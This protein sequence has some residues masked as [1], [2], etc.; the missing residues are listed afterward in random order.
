MKHLFSLFS[1]FLRPFRRQLAS[2]LARDSFTLVFFLFLAGV[3]FYRYSVFV[4]S[5]PGQYHLPLFSG[6][7]LSFLVWFFLNFW[8]KPSLTEKE[9]LLFGESTLPLKSLVWYFFLRE[10]GRKILPLLLSFLLLLPIINALS[11]PLLV[12][13][14]I[15]VSLPIVWFRYLLWAY[16]FRIS[17]DKRS[18]LLWLT[19]LTVTWIGIVNYPILV[20]VG[21]GIEIFTLFFLLKKIFSSFSHSF[22]TYSAF[23]LSSHSIPRKQTQKRKVSVIES[24]LHY[25]L[26]V[27]DKPSLI[28]GILVVIGILIGLGMVL[29]SS[30]TLEKQQLKNGLIL[31]W[32]VVFVGVSSLAGILSSHP[33]WFLCR[34]Q[35]I[36]FWRAS[37]LSQIKTLLVLPLLV[38]FLVW[39]SLV[40]PLETLFSF[41]CGLLWVEMIWSL[42]FL[43][44]ERPIFEALVFVFFFLAFLIGEYS[45]SWGFIPV[46]SGIAYFL[47]KKAKQKYTQKWEDVP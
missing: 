13:I 36:P 6:L 22:I 10:M 37:L 4:H 27:S 5:L 40:L 41:L 28:S 47:W 45:L 16:W 11:L 18:C 24:L 42:H 33:W 12:K 38:P 35:P 14:L 43:I 17:I 39:S 29:A 32:L 1:F 8:G 30:P 46:A 23:F 7:W 34:L 3:V 20:P 25:F 9:K 21:L 44:G 2:H 31:L 19:L 15:F 26:S